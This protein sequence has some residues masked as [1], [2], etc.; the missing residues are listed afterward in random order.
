MRDPELQRSK[1]ETAAAL[2]RPGDLRLET[3][4]RAAMPKSKATQVR[5]TVPVVNA[6]SLTAVVSKLLSLNTDGSRA[7]NFNALVL[8][9]NSVSVRA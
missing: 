5:R 9:Q 2:G 3:S 7:R 6:Q 8:I 4:K 1:L